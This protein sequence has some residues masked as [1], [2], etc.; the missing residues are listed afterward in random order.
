MQG[1]I[2]RPGNVL[3]IQGLPFTTRGA[4]LLPAGVF[5]AFS[6]AG[7]AK[8]AKPQAPSLLCLQ[9]LPSSELGVVLS[10]DD[11]QVAALGQLP[12]AGQVAE[13]RC[14]AASQVLVCVIAILA[15]DNRWCQLLSLQACESWLRSPPRTADCCARC[16]VQRGLRNHCRAW[17][18]AFENERRFQQWQAAYGEAAAAGQPQGPQA[19]ALREEAQ[20]LLQGLLDVLSGGGLESALTRQQARV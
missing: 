8:G 1:S 17:A 20:Q 6:D 18:L 11:T 3:P 13:A 19:D 5:V 9:V 12:D 2:L 7:I 4:S 16:Q 10:A 14:A 15:H